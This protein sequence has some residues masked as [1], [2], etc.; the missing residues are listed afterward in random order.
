MSIQ[1]DTAVKFVIG[2][3]LLVLILLW[4]DMVACFRGAWW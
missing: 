4:P 1:W 2:A 3:S